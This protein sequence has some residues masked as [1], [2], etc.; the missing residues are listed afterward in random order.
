MSSIFPVL[1]DGRQ[2]AP[3]QQSN[4]TQEW[5]TALAGAHQR[6]RTFCCCSPG[7]PVRLVVK[8]YSAGTDAVRF[9]LARWPGTGLAHT[10][11]CRFFNEDD[12][13][14]TG[15]VSALEDLGDG[16]V[17]IHLADSLQR[18]VQKGKAAEYARSLPTPE[19][20]GDATVRRQDLASQ[21]M[22]LRNLW[23][24]A[25]LNIYRG[26]PR[27]WYQ[28]A[29]AAIQAAQRIVINRKNETLGDYL[30]VLSGA[31]DKA[32]N[33][34]NDH[35]MAK[36]TS[37]GT[38][39][40]LLGRL[41]DYNRDKL[42]VLLPTVERGTLPKTLVVTDML[43]RA[44]GQ[45]NFVRNVLDGAGFVVCL[46]AI[47][48]AGNDWW[49]T[50]SLATLT[51]S[52][53]GIPAASSAELD[54]EHHL[55]GRERTFLKPLSLK[56]TQETSQR[57]IYILLDGEQRTRWEVWGATEECSLAEMR[58]QVAQAAGTTRPVAAWSANPRQPYPDLA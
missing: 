26:T 28:I 29:F 14:G 16:R 9:G 32:V 56:P 34:H 49:K 58:G 50:V 2:F 44:A 55:R 46:A 19:N 37:T 12:E 41:K 17:R 20:R 5:T 7:N 25:G 39:M 1:I 18:T 43:D 24:H 27:A 11:T 6:E 51:T 52:D 57:P 3:D 47:E 22:L 15:A 35:V 30:F 4:E 23:R 40:Y 42:Q 36:V 53:N 38:R 10:I 45:T 21:D 13:E 48:P 54:F 33:A 31:G 8:R